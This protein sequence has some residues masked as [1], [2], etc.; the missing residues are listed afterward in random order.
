M[1]GLWTELGCSS[2]PTPTAPAHTPLCPR[3]G[4]LHHPSV[5]GCRE[6]DPCA[7]P[8]CLGPCF[9]SPSP[10]T[11]PMPCQS[12]LKS[13]C[14]YPHP[15]PCCTVPLP[16][17]PAWLPD[18]H[19]PPPPVPP[20]LKVDQALQQPHPSPLYPQPQVLP[21]LQTCPSCSRWIRPCSSQTQRRQQPR[22]PLS[23]VPPPL[24]LVLAAKS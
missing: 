5:W 4:A 6:I 22:G 21:Y 16:P 24:S 11:S 18:P 10:P 15:C 9:T 20:D 3:L 14:C 23:L 13:P 8:S 19:V 7:S 12:F 17:G 2:S 1:V